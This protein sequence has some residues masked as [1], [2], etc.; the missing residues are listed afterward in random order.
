MPR[1]KNVHI[2]RNTSGRWKVTQGG[3]TRST[4]KTQKSAETAGR[5]IAK[6]YRADLVTHGRDGKI[7]SKDSFGNDPKSIQDTEY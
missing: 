6:K 2:S 7:R 3:A 1:K 5:T 4:H